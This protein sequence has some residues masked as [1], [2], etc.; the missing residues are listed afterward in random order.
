[1]NFSETP[2]LVPLLFHAG[3]YRLLAED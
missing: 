3:Q 2:E 1:V